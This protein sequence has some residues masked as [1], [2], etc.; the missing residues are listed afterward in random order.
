MVTDEYM[1]G[2]PVDLRDPAMAG[3]E[4]TGPYGDFERRA[5]RVVASSSG[6]RTVIQ[7]DGA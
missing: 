2:Y 5:A 4:A 7:D 1:P 6:L 3:R